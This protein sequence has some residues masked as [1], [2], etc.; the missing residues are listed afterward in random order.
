MASSN[1][2]RVVI[3][4]EATY[5]TTPGSG[6]FETIRMT[7]ESLTGTPETTES[8]LLRTDRLT[9]GQVNTGLTINGSV[10]FELAK[11]NALDLLMRC[12]MMQDAYVSDTPIT[13]DLTI[14][15][16]LK[17]IT[18]TSGDWNTDVVVGDVIT[19]S[20]FLDANNNTQVMVTA[21]NSATEISYAGPESLADET[22]SGTEFVVADKATIGTDYPSLSIEKAFLDVTDRAINYRGMYV[23]GMDLNIAYG[24]LVSGSFSFVGNNYEPVDAAADF[25]T[26]GRTINSPGTANVMNGSI[27]MPFIASSTQG[28][29][30]EEDF[31]IQ[32]LN[33]S[34]TNNASAQTCIGERAPKN[35]SINTANVNIT[36][37]AYLSSSTWGLLNKKETQESFAIGFIVKNEGGFYGFYIPA[38]QITFQDPNSPG[39][40]QDIIISADGQAKVGDN[41][42]SSLTI[43]KG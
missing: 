39:A 18:R 26:D 12:A 25:M 24:E 41:G 16:T 43:Y 22:G 3:I 7:S 33:I 10:D 6:D 30:S 19:L 42:E 14:D 17:T 34:L 2:V 20:G 5:G 27:D 32:T 21:I 36:L 31:C 1:Q 40:N 4:E 8:G 15:D 11:D 28:A 35:Y 13:V 37:T 29:F 38:V 23:D 9:S